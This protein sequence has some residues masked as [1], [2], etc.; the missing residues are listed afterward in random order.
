MTQTHPRLPTTG[1]DFVPSQMA[2]DQTELLRRLL[3]QV[4][5]QLELRRKLVE[6]DQA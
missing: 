2:F 5:T 3:R 6:F 4:P 1:M